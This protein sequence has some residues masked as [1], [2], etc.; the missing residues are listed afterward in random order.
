MAWARSCERATLHAR[1]PGDVFIYPAPVVVPDAPDVA[2]QK[3]W[4]ESWHFTPEHMPRSSKDWLHRGN[5]ILLGDQF[6]AIEG[7]CE[8]PASIQSAHQVTEMI[9]GV[10]TSH[11][12]DGRRMPIPLTDRRHPLDSVG[13]TP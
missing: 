11:F 9:Q 7:G 10:Y 1:S 3:I 13:G 12:A 5:Q 4:V 8:P 6:A 2:W